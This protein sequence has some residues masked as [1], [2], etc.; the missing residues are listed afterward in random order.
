MLADQNLADR[1]A[2]DGGFDR[3]LHIADVDSEAVGGR[4]IDDQIY[5]GLSAHLKRA[6]IGDAWNFSHHILNLIGFGF[7]GLQ[8]GAKEFDGEFALD[9]AHGF[10]DVVGNGLGEIPVHAGKLVQLGVHG[11]D[12]VVFGFEF[13]SATSNGAADRQRIPCCRSRWHRCHHRDGRPGSRFV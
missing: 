10:F 3:V 13:G 7:Q 2:A 8:V 1:F 11:G 12:E 6:Q 4:A 5:V 9:A